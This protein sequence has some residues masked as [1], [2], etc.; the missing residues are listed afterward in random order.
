MSMTPFNQRKAIKSV[1]AKWENQYPV[2]STK[3]KTDITA[4]LRKL[5]F[6]TATAEQIDKIIGNGSWTH[7][8][9]S[10]CSDYGDEGVEFGG[11]SICYTC[12][13]SA[14]AVLKTLRG[15]DK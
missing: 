13:V 2:G 8:F 6:K 15:V 10:E 7:L 14:V 11:S 1:L 3:D 9:C 5:D 4:E 12:L